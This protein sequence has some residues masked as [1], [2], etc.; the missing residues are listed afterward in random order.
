M[1]LELRWLQK[2]VARG[3]PVK[4]TDASPQSGQPA[5]LL[6]S[7]IW[8]PAYTACVLTLMPVGRLSLPHYPWT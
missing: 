5:W 6:D 4:V 1:P 2:K 7:G 8:P 3:G